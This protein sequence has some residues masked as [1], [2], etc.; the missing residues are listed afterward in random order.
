MQHR[1]AQIFLWIL[2]TAAF[3]HT[4]LALSY[5]WANPILE[6]HS[7]RQ[8]QTALSAYFLGLGGP[9]WKYET[10]LLG[11]P[12]SI[13]FELPI[14]QWLVAKFQLVSGWPWEQS[15]RAVGRFFFIALLWPLYDC[16]KSLGLGK[17]GRVAALILYCL[18]PLYLFW[19]RTFLIESTAL[20]FALAYFA[21]F[22]RILDRPRISWLLFTAIAGV[23]AGSVKVTTAF[24]FFLLAGLLTLGHLFSDWR[25]GRFKINPWVKRI[26]AGFLFPGVASLAWVI[27]S[28]GM[29]EEN[30]LA[31]F[32]TSASLTQWNFGTLEQRLDPATWYMLFRK[33]MHDS[34]GH[35]TTWII[36]LLLLPAISRSHIYMALA[37]LVSFLVAPMVFTNLHIQHNYYWY[38][39]GIFLLVYVAIVVDGLAGSKIRGLQLAGMALLLL[40]GGLSL[41]HY[42]KFPYYWQLNDVPAYYDIKAPLDKMLGDTDVI[43]ILGNDWYPAIPWAAK[44][45]AIMVRDDI[46]PDSQAFQQSLARLAADGK[47]IG[48]V[49]DCYPSRPNGAAEMLAMRSAVKF[50]ANKTYRGSC[51]IYPALEN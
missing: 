43:L 8:A 44:R 38:A 41:R 7:F 23:L 37:A 32:I 42:Y 27:F 36:S 10:P 33:T 12:W 48:A 39:N 45:R 46:K 6:E 13:P 4:F 18:S 3:L 11:A 35:R 28:D 20:F 14:Y 16:L 2:F 24:T 15:G 19:S 31:V 49:L 47:K 21:G 17:S 26:A 5:G 30:P 40:A 9:F 50:S 29:K 22:L 34:M 25:R 1:A 51:E